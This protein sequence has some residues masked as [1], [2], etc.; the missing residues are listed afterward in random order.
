MVMTRRS[1]QKTKAV[2]AIRSLRDY[3]DE[4]DQILDNVMRVLKKEYKAIKE[5]RLTELEA[6]SEEKSSCMLN[7]QANDQRLKLHPQAEL[8]KTEYLPR[9]NAIKAKL[10]QCKQQNEVN[11]KLISLAMASNRRLSAVL[12]NAR[13]KMSKNMTYTDIGNTVVTT[14]LRVNTNV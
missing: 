4:Q 5:R 3:L 10:T 14:P 9:V 7:L 11:G 1:M 2:P 12:M 13:D 8:L 6:I